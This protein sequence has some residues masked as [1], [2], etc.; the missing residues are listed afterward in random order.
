MLFA[1]RASPCVPLPTLLGAT[2]AVL[3]SSPVDGYCFHFVVK[4]SQASILTYRYISV[5][6]WFYVFKK[7]SGLA[8][9][10]LSMRDYGRWF[11]SQMAVYL[12]VPFSL[13]RWRHVFCYQN[14]ICTMMIE[15][16]SEQSRSF[17][18][19]Q[20]AAPAAAGA[21]LCV[22]IL[23]CCCCSSSSAPL[24]LCVL[25]CCCCCCSSSS[26]AASCCRCHIVP[27]G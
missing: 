23:L 27:D 22:A 19:I 9:R 3:A 25:L 6:I 13:F 5:L 14:K 8:G 12:C 24:M 20:S 10:S 16:S 15:V 7:Y 11:E 2:S 17:I 4:M 1:R 26:A 18:C 21:A